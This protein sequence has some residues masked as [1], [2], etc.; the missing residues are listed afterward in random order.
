MTCTPY[1]LYYPYCY[2]IIAGLQFS[3]IK[4]NSIDD[5]MKMK[6][7]KREG[8]GNSHSLRAVNHSIHF[9]LS[10]ANWSWIDFRHSVYFGFI[11]RHI[12]FNF[13]PS[14]HCGL[15]WTEIDRPYQPAPRFP[16]L[17]WGALL[18]C[19]RLLFI[20]ARI[21]QYITLTAAVSFT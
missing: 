5:W 10:L 4:F 13:I 6:R 2:N 14:F 1:D 16:S 11:V 8:N 20:T 19:F 15:K 9:A 3:F 17:K 7:T 21:A 12:S 18:R